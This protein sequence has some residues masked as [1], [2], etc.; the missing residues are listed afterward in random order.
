MR[1]AAVA[2]ENVLVELSDVAEHC[3]DFGQPPLATAAAAIEGD[4]NYSVRLVG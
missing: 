3:L 4:V 2:R 1:G